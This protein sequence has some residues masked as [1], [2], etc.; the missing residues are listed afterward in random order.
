MRRMRMYGNPKVLA[1]RLNAVY[2][3]MES[4]VYLRIK[5]KGFSDVLVLKARSNSSWMVSNES[6]APDM[7]KDYDNSEFSGYDENEVIL[8]LEDRIS[9]IWLDDKTVFST[10]ADFID[11][12]DDLD[13]REPEFRTTVHLPMSVTV[14]LRALKDKT[15]KDMRHIICDA[16]KAYL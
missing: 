13:V 1:E 14:A 7:F 8:Q 16:V 15:G 4:P 9:R 2:G 5:V 6:M 11:W 10:W 3:N 12:L